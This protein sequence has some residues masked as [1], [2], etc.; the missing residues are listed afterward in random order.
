[1]DAKFVTYEEFG[2]KGDGIADDFAAIKKAHDFAN[3]NKLPVIA[4]PGAKYYIHHTRMG[5]EKAQ[6]VVIKTNTV[7]ENAEFVIDDRDINYFETPDMATTHIF[8]V[9]SDYPAERIEDEAALNSMFAGG[10]GKATK[11]INVGRDYPVMII[12]YNK[13]DTVYRRKGYGGYMGSWMHEVIVLDKD[14]NVDPETPVMFDYRHIDYVDIYRLDIEHITIKGGTV[15]TRA[16]RVNARTKNEKGENRDTGYFARGLDVKRSFTTVDG[17]KH[18]VTDEVT[19]K[20]FVLQELHGAHYSGF[21]YGS[22][23]T[24]ILFKNCVLTGRRYYHVQGTYDFGANTVNKI[25]LDG[26]TQHNFWVTYDEEKDVVA[27]AKRDD[28][29]SVTSMCWPTIAGKKFKLHWGLGGTNFCKNMEYLNSTL[30]RFDAH[31]GLYNGKI[32]NCTVNYMALTGNGDFIVEDTDWYSEGTGGN[33]ASMFHLRADYGSTWEGEIKVKNLNAYVYTEDKAFMFLHSYANWYYG[34]IAH[35]PTISID[36]LRIFDIKTFEPVA[37]DYEV[38]ML[39][40]SIAREPAMHL[41]ETVNVLS[42]YPYVDL[43]GDGIVD[44]TDKP[45]IKEETKN[46]WSGFEVEGCYKN[47]NPVAPPKY[48]KITN[49]RNYTFNIPKTYDEARAIP[50]IN[51]KAN[52]GF[53]GTTKF[54]YGDGENEYLLGTNH[55]DKKPFKF[56]PF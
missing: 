9:A 3:E 53:F 31:S 49:A 16:C 51:G 46:H 15:T 56:I 47:L 50:D 5:E 32:I 8:T 23:A 17:L 27:P 36:N 48:V 19:P 44:G 38:D 37:D 30:S 2:A 14:G 33:S 25:V 26:C 28:P 12:P 21:F 39:Q 1:M 40:G 45:Y 42:T 29:G 4:K 43:D 11:K 6:T 13:K 52:E 41:P 7:W 24:N 20:E 34:Y 18:Y 55:G 10:L 22:C 54:Y 35:M